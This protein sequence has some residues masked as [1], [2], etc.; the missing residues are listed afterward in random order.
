MHASS[1]SA[2]QGRTCARR[3]T[4]SPG[5]WRSEGSSRLEGQSRRDGAVRTTGALTWI[6]AHSSDTFFNVTLNEVELS[7]FADRELVT[8]VFGDGDCHTHPASGDDRNAHTGTKAGIEISDDTWVALE[9]EQHDSMMGSGIRLRDIS[10]PLAAEGIS[11]LF[12]ST[13]ISDV[14]RAGRTVPKDLS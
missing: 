2:Y 1:C 12:L 3:A 7:I 5:A 8:A 11:I 14:S 9:V 6:Y 4:P 13:Y 10:A